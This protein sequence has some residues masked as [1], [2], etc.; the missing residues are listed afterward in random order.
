MEISN[1]MKIYHADLFAN[2]AK[3]SCSCANISLKMGI[4][5]PIWSITF[6]AHGDMYGCIFELSIVACWIKKSRSPKNKNTLKII[7]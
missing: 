3:K 2:A 4:T 1:M 7:L 6:G 5:L